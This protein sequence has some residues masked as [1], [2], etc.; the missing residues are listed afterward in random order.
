MATPTL[1]LAG[2]IGGTK[3]ILQLVTVPGEYDA[4]ALGE[5]LEVRYEKE[6]PSGDFPDLVPMVTQFLQ[7][8]IATNALDKTEKPV[9]ACFG[10]AGPVVDNT[11]KLTNLGWSLSGDHLATAL[12][13][14]TV[15]LINDFVAVGYGVLGLDQSQLHVL[16]EGDRDPEAPI[17][18]IGAGTGLGQGFAIKTGDRHRVFGCEGGHVD[19]A[20][21]SEREWGLLEYLRDHLEISRVSV[22]RVVSGMGIVGIYQY[23]R[24]LNP[25]D[26]IAAIDQAIQ[27]QS[28]EERGADPGALI[29]KGAQAGESICVAT[30]GM[31]IR[32]Y[33]AETG[34][35]ALKLLPRGG[36]YIAGGIAAKNLALMTDGEFM[37]AFKAKGRMGG[38][39]EDVPLAIVLEPRVGL[40]G[41]AICAAQG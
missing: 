19:F 2:D 3:T 9:R 37:K 10:I 29:S 36:L 28:G 20:P 26:A 1:L 7:E 13:I 5:A 22:E 32:A 30:M 12:D 6:Y 23:L 25:G 18:V 14:G 4:D 16:Q 15:T 17:G 40:L 38:L 39:L 34:N 24:D 35:L 31:F 8:A 27:G 41:A 21:R 11:S 33:G